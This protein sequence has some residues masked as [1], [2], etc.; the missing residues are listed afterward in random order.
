L[1]NEGALLG[2]L[3]ARLRHLQHRYTRPA[4]SG[5][6]VFRGQPRV[7]FAVGDNPGISQVEL[8]KIVHVQPPTAT[9][10]ID[11]MVQAGFLTRQADPNDHRANR[12]FLTDR[13]KRVLITLRQIHERE[14]DEIFSV[15]SADEKEQFR[16]LIRRLSDRYG[17]TMGD[18]PS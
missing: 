17:S 11:R 14:E 10:M 4:L 3:L 7:L 6:G 5:L 15:L 1:E 9:R 12:V 8:T 13:G 18:P 16:S 2:L